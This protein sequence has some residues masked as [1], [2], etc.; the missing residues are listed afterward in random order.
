MDPITAVTLGLT[1]LDGVEKAIA[2][3]ED[4]MGIVAQG[5]AILQ[6]MQDEKRDPTADELVALNA[7]TG[8][9]QAAINTDPP[10]P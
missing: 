6:K 7:L 10:A 1:I 4:A 2:A 5:R 9:E 8:A 3:G